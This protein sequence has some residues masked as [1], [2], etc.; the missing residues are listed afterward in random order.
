MTLR[1]TI[2]QARLYQLWAVGLHGASYAEGKEGI[3]ACFQ[4]LSG[5][6]L[7]TLPILGRNHDLVIQ[8]R[9]DCT[10][11]GKTLALI[12]EERLGFEYWDKALCVLPI[13]TFPW[14]RALMEAKGH[15]W[16]RNRESLLNQEHPGA[17]AAVKS[18][19]TRHG[20]LA[21]RELKDLNVAQGDHRSW[22]STKA[23]NGALEVLWNKGELSVSHRRN[24]RRYFDLTERV[25]PKR[26]YEEVVPSLDAFFQY[27]FIKRVNTVGLLPARGDAEVWA[28]LRAARTDK[29]PE[30]IIAAGKATVVEVAGIKAP[31]YAAAD[32]KEG[33]AQAEKVSLDAGARFIAPLDPLLWARRVLA[34]LWSFDYVWEVYKP[35]QK[36]I[37]GYYV[38]PILCGYRFVARFDSRYDR[39][40]KT[41]HVLAYYEEKD[42][43]PLMHPVIHT[44]F[45]RFLTYLDGE[46][47]VLPNGEVW[48][49]NGGRGNG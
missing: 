19:I 30:E 16:E 25:I 38:L 28:L 10:H 11:P 7:D 5:I 29:I 23:A 42:G 46:R 44:G 40:A 27:L 34:R 18:A 36:R 31:F 9:V 13:D 20:P 4:D 6:Q 49:C 33:L 32:A 48:K 35:V 21:S 47:I 43:L 37:F 8:A 1:W 26:F 14:F 15:V 22:K 12:H 17:I 3:R 45:Q 2:E 24:Y 39:A 41:L